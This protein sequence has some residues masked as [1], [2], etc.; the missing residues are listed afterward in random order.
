MIKEKFSHI[1]KFYLLG[2]EPFLNP[3]INKYICEIRELLPDSELYI[4]TNG[5]L[6]EKLPKETLEC[7]KDN[8][9]WISISEYKPTSKKI[10]TICD[11]L[12]KYKILFEIRR[13]KDRQKFCLP[14]S[15]SEESKYPRT[16]ISS[17]CVTIWNG[18]ISRCP[19]LM[20]ISYFNTYFNTHLP[21]SGVMELKNCAT[22]D[23]LLAI[24]KED[25]PLCRHC[26][27]NEIEWEICGRTPKLED[28]A[29]ND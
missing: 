2:G 13:A 11:I 21:E 14:L 6:I 3:E 29:V 4:V 22:G 8:H 15:L 19:Q 10:H 1:I 12:N 16:C 25:V 24:L 5:L 26:V 18:K 20:Y 23:D 9:V 27:K 17:I 7:I 28:F